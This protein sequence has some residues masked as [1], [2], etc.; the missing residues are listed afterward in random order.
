MIKRRFKAVRLLVAGL[1]NLYISGDNNRFRGYLDW[2][3]RDKRRPARCVINGRKR[4][5]NAGGFGFGSFG[6]VRKR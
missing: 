1:S 2:L 4:S 6:K 3:V 5:V